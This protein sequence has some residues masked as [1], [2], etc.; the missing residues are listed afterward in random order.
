MVEQF[1]ECPECGKN[2]GYCN[3][4]RQ[5]FFFC[6]EHR[7]TWTAGVNLFSSWREESEEDWHAA[8]EKLKDYRVVDLDGRDL[9][10][11]TLG[12][13]TSLEAMM[14]P[15]APS[16][17]LEDRLPRFGEA[18]YPGELRDLMNELDGRRQEVVADLGVGHPLFRII[19]FA[20]RSGDLEELR[21]ARAAGHGAARCGYYHWSW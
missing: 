8:W 17:G 4:Y 6:E 9:I 14:P 2:D 15:P 7:I 12:E 19:D 11:P 13:V 20:L 5:H 10:G 3:I 21:T 16:T 18:P 1:G